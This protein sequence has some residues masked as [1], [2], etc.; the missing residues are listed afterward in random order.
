M[1]SPPPPMLV[2]PGRGSGIA[3]SA[4]R[5]APGIIP[6]LLRSPAAAACSQ[7]GSSAAELNSRT[8]GPR[9]GWPTTFFLA[10][11]PRVLA[12]TN[13]RSRSG[14]IAIISLRISATALGPAWPGR[15]PRP[16]HHHQPLARAEDQPR[17]IQNLQVLGDAPPDRPAAMSRPVAGSAHLH[18]TIPPRY[19]TPDLL[20]P[21]HRRLKPSCDV[22]DVSKYACAS[23]SF[24]ARRNKSGASPNQQ[25][26]PPLRRLHASERPKRG[27][28]IQD[29]P[30]RASSA[31]RC[32][33]S[34]VRHRPD[35]WV[36]LFLGRCQQQRLEDHSL[37][38]GTQL[39]ETSPA[40]GSA[41]TR[42]SLELLDSSVAR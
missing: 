2:N 28:N 1:T 21:Q 27:G 19:D 32:A 15:S 22:I 25:R 8:A 24:P 36:N 11:A 23:P 38:A 41:R 10:F 7:H 39:L 26:R 37:V 9:A 30:W 6:A 12:T 35:A 42:G 33:A 40:T 5:P 14:R 34:S 13:S 17:L 4:H 3:S 29:L 20:I 31:D 18:A 16:L